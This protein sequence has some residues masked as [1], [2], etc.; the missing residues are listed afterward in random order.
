MTRQPI[1]AYSESGAMADVFVSYSRRDS[2][3]VGRIVDSVEQR[4]KE[5]WLDTEGLVDGEVFPAAIRSAI[6]QSDTFLFVISPAA[7]DSPF[8]ESEVGYAGDL[9]KR[10][11]PVLRE[12]VPDHDLPPEIRDR[13]WIPFTERRCVRFIGCSGCSP[14]WTGSGPPSRT[15]PVALKALEWDAEGP[16]HELPAAWLG[17]EGR[18][19]VAGVSARGRRP[20]AHAAPARVRSRQPGG[21]SAAPAGNDGRGGGDRGGRDRPAGIR[22]DIQG[23]GGVRT[24]ERPCSG[25]GRREPGPAAQRPRDFPDPWDASG[26]REAHPT[27]SVRPPCRARRLAARARPADSGTP[28]DMWGPTSA[29]IRPD[30]HEIAEATC[31]GLVRILDAATGRVLRSNH[32]DSEVFSLAYSPDGHEL[33]AATGAGVWMINPQ[34]QA[35]VT[36]QGA[37][38]SGAARWL[39]ARMGGS[40]R[41][42]PRQDSQSVL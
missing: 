24:G 42:T 18:R 15:H 7:V 36:W 23:A 1:A 32:I 12:P 20:R 13:N 40:S 2:D 10:I 29:A 27:V 4:G 22:A 33:A 39:S 17:A 6:E 3:F 30:G 26:A 37:V 16:G 41:S 31:A 21:S 14:R 19:G 38:S 25:A 28:R 8:C 34:T 9:H 5:A 11:V 35:A